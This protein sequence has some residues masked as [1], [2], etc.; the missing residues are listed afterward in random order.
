MKRRDFRKY[1]GSMR[2]TRLWPL[3][4]LLAILVF[5]IVAFAPL[6]AFAYD[7]PLDGVPDSA[8]LEVDIQAFMW[9][10]YSGESV[11]FQVDW[12]LLDDL[13]DG[14]AVVETD[15][16]LLW[17]VNGD[18]YIIIH[19]SEWEVLGNIG[20]Q[21]LELWIEYRS[22]DEE[23]GHGG[24]FTQITTTPTI[25]NEGERGY[26]GVYDFDWQLKKLSIYT[27]HKGNYRCVVFFELWDP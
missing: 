16:D 9:I 19:R 10:Y 7:P 21:S 13:T 6:S 18:W 8:Q 12:S 24:R 2:S 4:S 20:D 14:S 27:T 15:D 11:Q 25:I 23:G 3:R 17:C 5:G 26:W 22:Q 1:S